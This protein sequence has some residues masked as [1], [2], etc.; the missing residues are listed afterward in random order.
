MNKNHIVR[1]RNQR[2]K[3]VLK[4][5]SMQTAHTYQYCFEVLCDMFEEGHVLGVN[6][7]DKLFERLTQLDN[8][9]PF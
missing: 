7:Q 2:M 9:A 4:S 6:T 1:V 5:V 3:N 8:D